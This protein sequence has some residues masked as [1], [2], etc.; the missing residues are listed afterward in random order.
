M[1]SGDRAHAS[2]CLC[3]CMYAWRT[4]VDIGISLNG[5]PLY[6]GLL[7]DLGI[8]HMSGLASQLDSGDV[9]SSPSECWS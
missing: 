2:V 4:D 1:C 8:I 7:L 3:R 6:F 5:C 9:L